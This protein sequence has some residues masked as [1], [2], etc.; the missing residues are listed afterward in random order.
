[1]LTLRGIPKNMKRP[2]LG[3]IGSSESD[4]EGREKTILVNPGI[5]KK[6]LDGYMA[7]IC[8]NAE[9]RSGTKC[10]RLPV[11]YNIK[12]LELLSEGDVVEIFPNGVISV[13]YQ[14]NSGH[15]VIFV[16]S[17]CDCNCIMCP[18]P[19]DNNEGN[20]TELNLK[21]ISLMSTTINEIALTGVT[22]HINPS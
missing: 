10:L 12:G 13:L 11:V 6:P 19:I 7:V 17:K 2:L 22:S 1:M 3:R 8:S 9:L 16:T 21:L 5:T 15:N 14:I 18:Q 20:L 4:K